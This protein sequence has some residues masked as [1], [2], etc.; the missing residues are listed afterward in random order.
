MKRFY[1]RLGG[2][3]LA[4]RRG[5]EKLYFPTLEDRFER[6]LF[7]FNTWSDPMKFSARQ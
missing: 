3:Q 7:S 1:F 5:M 2:T 4:V 6:T